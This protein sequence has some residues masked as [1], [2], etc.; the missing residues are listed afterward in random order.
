MKKITEI[1]LIFLLI[2]I[3][4]GGYAQKVEL[5]KID[6]LQDSVRILNDRIN[7]LGKSYPKIQEDINQQNL[8]E[9]LIL[10]KET[11]QAQ[12]SLI[13]GFGTLYAWITIIIAILGLVLPILIHQFGIKPAR[14]AVTDLQKDI[15]KK[16]ENFLKSNRDKQITQAINNL[17]SENPELRNNAINY[18]SLTQHEGYNE[19]QSFK[20]YK[21]LKSKKVDD[22]ARLSLAYTFSHKRNE[23]GDDFFPEILKNNSNPNLKFYAFRYIANAGVKNYLDI[24]HDFLSK[25][26]SKE[27]DYITMMVSF[28]QVSKEALLILINESKIIDLFSNE[29]IKMIR[30]SIGNLKTSW[31]LN[32]EI[33]KSYLMTK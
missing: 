4:T 7:N 32:D 2:F 22:T 1:G 33:E 17:E 13:D 12:N 18:L 19:E 21:L 3:S 26:D 6:K 9:Q 5:S 16:I 29:Q 8:N 31:N 30:N 14:Q 28:Q 20:I 27:N 24:L 25:I 10:A 15:D 23:Y 11:I